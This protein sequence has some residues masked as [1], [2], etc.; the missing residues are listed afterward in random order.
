MFFPL[1]FNCLQNIFTA[2]FFSLFSNF[3]SLSLCPFFPCFQNVNTDF[4][5][6]SHPKQS[7]NPILCGRLFRIEP[8]KFNGKTTILTRKTSFPLI[9]IIRNSSFKNVCVQRK[10]KTRQQEEK[11]NTLHSKTSGKIFSRFCVQRWTKTTRFS[12]GMNRFIALYNNK[13]RA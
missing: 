12:C 9:Q 7:F 8:T 4:S 13:T 3:L 1:L 5:H 6:I 10:T 2:L 11:T